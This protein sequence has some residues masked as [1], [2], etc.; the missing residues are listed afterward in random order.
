MKIINR[1]KYEEKYKNVFLKKSRD[2]APLWWF[3]Q[4]LFKLWIIY[5]KLTKRDFTSTAKNLGNA[6][7]ET[8][9][10][11]NLIDIGGGSGWMS[12]YWQAGGLYTVLDPLFRKFRNSFF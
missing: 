1:D 10:S 11:G 6:I 7:G 8:E 4:V 2:N 3:Y 12:K 5:T 9:I